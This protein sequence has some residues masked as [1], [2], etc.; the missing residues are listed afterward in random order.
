[1]ATSSLACCLLVRC[2]AIRPVCCIGQLLGYRSARLARAVK[3]FVIVVD[4][5]SRRLWWWHIVEYQGLVSVSLSQPPSISSSFLAPL[6]PRT[7]LF[8]LVAV[9]DNGIHIMIAAG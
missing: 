3:T 4:S 9:R 2:C 5:P 7:I 6:A 1:M 8:G